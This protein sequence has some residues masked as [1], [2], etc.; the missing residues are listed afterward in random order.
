MIDT[1]ASASLIP[2]SLVPKQTLHPTPVRLSTANGEAIKVH[3]QVSALLA[4]PNLRRI[5]RWIFVVA[6]VCQ[7]L[8]GYDF[9]EHNALVIDC[10]DKVLYDRVTRRAFYASDCEEPVSK[11]QINSV[12]DYPSYVQEIL[13]K[14]PSVIA[15]YDLRAAQQSDSNVF[16]RRRHLRPHKN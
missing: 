12:V 5:Y 7:P 3:G 14:Y 4:L 10:G 2:L 1:G 6:D 16:H 8:L 11:I 15:P 13:A 9:L